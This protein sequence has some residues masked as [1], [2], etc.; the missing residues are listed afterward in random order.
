MLA[1]AERA[2]VVGATAVARLWDA[3][4]RR[5]YRKS[6]T[7]ARTPPSIMYNIT[8]GQHIGMAARYP[9]L[10]AAF[11]GRRL[12]QSLHKKKPKA[13]P[14]SVDTGFRPQLNSRL[15]QGSWPLVGFALQV[16]SATAH[17]LKQAMRSRSFVS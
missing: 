12:G 17:R 4:N 2:T 8:L 15:S 10:S 16:R 6:R 1:E 9:R 5:N 14:K 7:Q 3:S 13:D 11:V